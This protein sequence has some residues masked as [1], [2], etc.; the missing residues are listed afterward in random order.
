MG[1]REN[2]DLARESTNLVGGTSVASFIFV[3]DAG[4][5]GLFLEVI[6][7]LG[8]LEWGGSGEFLEDLSLNLIFEGVDSLVSCDL[9]RLVDG[10]FNTGARDAV[11][12]LEEF[13]FDEEERGL[14]LCLTA[15]SGEFFLNFDDGLDG[16]LGEGEGCFELFFGEFTGAAFD[17]ERFGFGADVHEVEIAL[18]IFVMRRVSDE[19]A[20]DASDADGGDGAGPRNIGDHEG[21]RGAVEGKDIGIIL[22]ICAEEDGDDLSVVV[23]AFRKEGAQGAIDHPAGE[24]LFLGGAAFTAEVASGDATDGGGFFFIFDGEGEK[25]LAIFDFGGGDGG[26]DD[27]GFT[28]GDEG[29]AVGEFGKFSGFDGEVAIA[30]TGG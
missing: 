1:A 12:D 19:F 22:A 2:A 18:G 29:G 14:A 13:V 25:I 11:G 23:V 24:D 4:A 15:G 17:H 7:S 21:G 6:E 5:E 28:H 3:E 27:D 9:G 26:D 16:V 8:N 30:D 10:G 20:G